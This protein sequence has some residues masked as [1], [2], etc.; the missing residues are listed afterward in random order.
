MGEP[1][2]PGPLGSILFRGNDRLQR[3]AQFDPSHV[4][5]GEPESAHVKKIQDA[6]RQ[7]FNAQIPETEKN[8][9]PETT[10]AVVAFKTDR[11]IFTRGTRSIDPIVGINTIRKLDELLQDNDRRRRGR[12][13]DGDLGPSAVV[14]PDTP[15]SGEA[16]LAGF[17]AA[18]LV[19]TGPG[20]EWTR[21]DPFKPITQMIPVGL[22]RKLLVKPIGSAAVG[23]RIDREA[24]ASIAD[25]DQGSVT[26]RG[27]A[28]GKARLTISV[29]THTPVLVELVVR[30]AK[31][32][33][34][35]VFHL[36]PPKIPGTAVAFQTS[37][38]PGLNG[39]YGSQTNLTF[40]AG[41]T[42]DITT[43]VMDGAPTVIDTNLPLFFSEQ[44]GP[45]IA[46]R[47]TL[48]FAD[49][50]REVRNTSAVTVFVSPNIKDQEGDSI[51]GRGGLRTK[52]AW[53]Q[54]A[55]S[56]NASSLTIPSHEVGHSLGLPHI[57]APK[58]ETFLMNPVVQVNNT[59]IPSETLEDLIV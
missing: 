4:K 33:P 38:L 58:N 13:G 54:L 49:L 57:T 24:I 23:F 8:Y 22:T 30:A 11:D 59:I 40:T 46:T 51:R 20:T 19:H 44:I 39:V 37:L 25:S 9:G 28:P 21:R 14:K 48:R 3:C 16:N 15:I 29:E 10:K 47:P 5:P 27:N 42:R 55:V 36:G 6:L 1:A 17:S 50:Q 45:P 52:V 7:V 12:G 18:R 53:F 43:M 26:L 34:L 31:S 35:D 2:V 32:I 41:A 56:V